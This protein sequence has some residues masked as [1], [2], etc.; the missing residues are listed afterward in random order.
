MSEPRD[1]LR[2]LLRVI[3]DDVEP[4][5]RRYRSHIECAKGCSDCCHQTFRISNLEGA[6]LR[7]GLA[8]AS[9]EL[10]AD[11]LARAHAYAPDTRAP[12]PV[13]SEDG[14]CRLYEHRPRICRKY[15]IPLWNPQRPE[16]VD[17]CPKNFVGVHDI[18]ADLIIEPQARWAEAWIEIR[19]RDEAA[20]ATATIAAQL[21]VSVTEDA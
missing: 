12:C 3:D 4:V 16:R 11:I 13:L 15:G 10:R 18:D 19:E 6:Y 5:V 2:H 14:A 17:T 8:A 9:P 1:R 7:E 21:T 20:R